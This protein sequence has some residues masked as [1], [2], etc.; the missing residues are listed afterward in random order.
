MDTTARAP[1]S[2][3]RAGRVDERVDPRAL[4]AD[5]VEHAARRL[6]HPR[7]RPAGPRLAR[8]RL[9]DHRAERGRRSKNGAARAPPPRTRTRSSPG[10]AGQRAGEVMVTPR[11]QRRPARASWRDAAPRASRPGPCRRRPSGPGRARTPGRPRRSARS[12]ASRRRRHDR[13]HAGHGD[14]DTAGH[15]LLDATWH[16]RPYDA[17]TSLTARSIP[18]GPQAR[19]RARRSARA[20]RQRV[21]D[22]PRGTVRA[23]VGGDGRPRRRPLGL[24]LAEDPV[25]AGGTDEEVDRGTRGPAARRPARTAG[26]SRSRRRPAGPRPGWPAA[27]TASPA[28]RHVQRL[29]CRTEASDTPCRF[30]A[31][32][33]RSARS[34]RRRRSGWPGRRRR[35][36]AAAAPEAGPPTEIATNCPGRNRSA[37]PPAAISIRWYAPTRRRASTSPRTCTG[38][39]RAV[40]SPSASRSCSCSS[41]SERTPRSPRIN[42]STPCTQRGHALHRGHARDPGGDGR[43]ADLVPVQARAGVPAAPHG[44]LKTRATSPSVIRC[45]Q[46]GRSGVPCR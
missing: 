26:P 15:R 14:P 5:R 24:Q 46:S 23:V 2:A 3:A 44:V 8:H 16:G 17:A 36:A 1:S 19:P 43:G 29:P 41:C 39:G 30:R 27:G 22:R 35:S 6:G 32:R 18:I 9:G 4:Q 28:G 45:T 40:R 20:R 34:R 31:P 42:A 21:R 13:Q 12:S 38:P 37:I 33:A 10:W 11:S 7:G 25:V